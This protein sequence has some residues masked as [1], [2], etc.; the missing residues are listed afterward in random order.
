MSWG[1]GRRRAAAMVTLALGAAGVAVLPLGPSAH[2]TAKVT[3]ARFGGADRYGTAQV[4][5]EHAFPSGSKTA[6]L[7]RGEDFPDGTKGFADALAGNYVAGF[8]SGPILLTAADSVPAA[9]LQALKDLK[10]KDVGILGGTSAISSV[11][12]A[13]LEATPSTNSAGGNLVIGRVGGADRYQTAALLAESIPASFVGTI[14]GLP[15]A[16]IATGEDFPD[17]LAGGPV[18]DASHLPLLLT[19]TDSLNP[20]T[21]GALS[22]LKIKAAL[23]LGGTSA[24]SSATETA[25]QQMG[26]TTQRLSGINR[27]QTAE[28][29]ANYAI[30]FLKFKNTLA[31]LARGDGYPDSLAGGPE[32]GTLGPY[33]IVLTSSPTVLGTDTATWLKSVNGTLAEVDALGGT[34]AVSDAVLKEAAGD[35][36]CTPTTSSTVPGGGLLTTLTSVLGGGGSSTSSTSTTVGPTTTVAA[37][38]CSAVATTTTSSS[39]SSSTTSTT[40]AG[41][42]TTTAGLPL[43]TLPVPITLPLPIPLP[44][45]PLGL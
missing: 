14:N 11:V 17:A 45:L 12:Q 9:T 22:A 21:A 23:I 2:A 26:I 33:P 20:S 32:A 27:Q 25:I 41:G 36:T 19:N 38:Q 29:I 39:T 28:Q 43:P 40:A 4:V 10:V 15:T 6:I 8:F 34:A 13:E 1:A 7:A 24:V 35:A 3:T 31:D 18:A 42:T 37:G 16:L 5:A 44:T 30:A